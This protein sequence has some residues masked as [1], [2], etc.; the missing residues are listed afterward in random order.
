MINCVQQLVGIHCIYVKLYN[1]RVKGSST[2]QTS[3]NS[4]WEVMYNV[5]HSE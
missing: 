5:P 3:T 1:V 4:N 2:G